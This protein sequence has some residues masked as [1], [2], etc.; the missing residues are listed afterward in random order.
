MTPKAADPTEDK[1]EEKS[2]KWKKLIQKK[3]LKRYKAVVLRQS[4]IK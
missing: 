3:M 4:K 1:E 2:T